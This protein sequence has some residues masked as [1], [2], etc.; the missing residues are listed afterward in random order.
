MVRPTES[1]HEKVRFA[2]RDAMRVMERARS[3]FLLFAWGGRLRGHR[4]HNATVL[5][6]LFS[7][8]LLLA[9]GAYCHSPTWDEVGHLPSGIAHWRTGA[10]H[11]YRV[12]P[13]L[14]RTIAAT[15][16]LL[17]GVDETFVDKT[18]HLHRVRGEWEAGRE[19]IDQNG[20]NAIWYF[21]IARWACLPFSL[22]GAAGCYLWASRLFDKHSGLLALALWCYSP[23][24]LAHGQLMTPD[25]GAASLGIVGH[26]SFWRWL[27]T[28]SLQ[29][30][31]VTGVLLGL[32]LLTKATWIFAFA[33]WPII[34]V[35]FHWAPCEGCSSWRTFARR[36]S[37]LVAILAIGLCIL[38]MGYGFEGTASNL[39]SFEFRS[40]ALGGSDLAERHVLTDNR[41]RDSWI[42]S[43]PVPV[44]ANYL[45]GI[46]VQKADFESGFPS[47]LRGEWR[48]SGWWYYYL[49]AALIKEPLGTWLLFFA[50][51]FAFLW[52]AQYRRSLRD[53]IC[54]MV[55]GLVLLVFVS[56]QTGFN[57]HFRYVL[58]ALP[59]G[60][61]WMSRVMHCVTL[62]HRF[63][64]IPVVLGVSW[65]IVSS[66]ACVPHSLSYFNELSGG[67]RNGHKHLLD[68]NI[69]WGQDLVH[70]KWWLERNPE[71]SPISIAYSL[72]EWLVSPSDYGIEDIGP[73][74]V[75]PPVAM[76][77][78]KVVGPV[79]GRYAVFVRAMYEHDRKYEYFQRFQPIDTIGYSVYIYDISLEEANQIRLELDLPLLVDAPSSR[80]AKPTNQD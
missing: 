52:S 74:P 41:F 1:V 46:D 15:P 28:P 65:S 72:P 69:D 54:L 14:V 19:F 68:S 71:Q 36:G 34:V 55:P 42:G 17:S 66:L 67:P 5:G 32:M 43:L 61:I 35:A 7:H 56:S 49:Y 51:I 38:H 2:A 80:T 3:T 24:I 22:L 58:P 9:Y 78:D 16:V 57:H 29:R 18:A 13:P 37:K 75:G 70:L 60:Y 39:G 33:I 76:P 73:P 45:L 27:H 23:N 77:S 31:L 63:L 20:E 40:K 26:Y 79:P 21:T 10:F 48:N 12:N 47:Y 4:F 44:P 62:R 50:S 11:W 59:F 25:V 8:S 53:E 30:T 6:I 64:C